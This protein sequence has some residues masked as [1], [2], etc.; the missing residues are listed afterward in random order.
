MHI[1]EFHMVQ[2]LVV[3][4]MDHLLLLMK[5]QQEAQQL[6]LTLEQLGRN[7]MQE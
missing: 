7:M 4:L 5:E 1:K 3:H 2:A 6:V